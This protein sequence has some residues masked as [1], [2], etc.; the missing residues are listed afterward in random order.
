M[1]KFV[2]PFIDTCKNVCE[3]FLSINA[4]PQNPFFIEKTETTN[5]DISGVI[6]LTG[7]AQGAVAISMKQDFAIYV[8]DVLTGDKHSAIDDIVVDAVGEIIN[9]IAGNVKKDLEEMFRLVI[10]L[11]TIVKGANHET[12]WPSQNARAIC[13]PFTVNEQYNFV[14]TVALKGTT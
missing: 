2:Q 14:L 4:I 13:I 8:A 6:G 1:E 3:S 12:F 7:E 11:P 10:S 5:W 9:I